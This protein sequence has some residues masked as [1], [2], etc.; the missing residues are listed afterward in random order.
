MDTGKRSMSE[1]RYIRQFAPDGEHFQTVKGKVSLETAHAWLIDPEQAKFTYL[2]PNG[3]V[4][5][6]NTRTGK[7]IER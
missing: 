3:K 1:D 6:V 2:L 5:I 4:R 7:A